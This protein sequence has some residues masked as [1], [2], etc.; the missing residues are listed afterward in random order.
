MFYIG[1]DNDGNAIEMDNA[2]VAQQAAVSMDQNFAVILP[3]TPARAVEQAGSGERT[4]QIET[5]SDTP[6]N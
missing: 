3:Q 6:G 2:D 5:F 4:W 1:H